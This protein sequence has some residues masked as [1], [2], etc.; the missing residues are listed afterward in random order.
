M[1]A[2]YNLVE[3]PG[4]CVVR[5][6][7]GTII[8][9]HHDEEFGVRID[10]FTLLGP[11]G[12]RN[13]MNVEQS[14]YE[15]FRLPRSDI[16]WLPT[17]IATGNRVRINA[18]LCGA[19]GGVEIANNIVSIGPRPASSKSKRKHQHAGRK[20]HPDRIKETKLIKGSFFGFDVGDYL[21]A[22]IKKLNGETISVFLVKPG[23]EYFLA[24]H[25][26]QPLE[27]TYQVVDTYIPEAG[28]ME[29]IKRLISAK[30]GNLTYAVWWTDMRNR[31][32]MAQLREKYDALVQ[33][34]TIEP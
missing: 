16:G 32:T 23:M 27:L 7:A 29:T 6:Y 15:D 11:R 19:S 24:L 8:K 21:H 34:S 26:N 5:T 31:F 3:D 18:Y 2:V 10:G 30:A 9:I 25:K 14:I 22:M 12:E 33:K 4:D 28:G 13:F 17:L 20:R 1:F